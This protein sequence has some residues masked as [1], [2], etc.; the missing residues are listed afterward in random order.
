VLTGALPILTA[1]VIA[2]AAAVLTGLLSPEQAYAGFGNSTIL[3][4]VLAFLVARSVVTCGLG[5]R[6]GHLVVSRFGRSTLG[7]SYCILAWTASCAGVSE[8]HGA[9]GRHLSA[10]V[11]AGQCN[12]RAARRR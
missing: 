7:L 12:R 4:I 1:S 5:T 10:R 6:I 9:I 11:L 8:Q 3:L 2:V